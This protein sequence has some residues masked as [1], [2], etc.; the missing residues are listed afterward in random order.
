[1]E[2]VLVYS[3]AICIYIYIYIY[4]LYRIYMLYPPEHLYHLYTLGPSTDW[5]SI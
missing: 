3:T 4:I 2:K 1:M 5:N